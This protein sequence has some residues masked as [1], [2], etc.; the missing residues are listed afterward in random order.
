MESH[1]AKKDYY[2]ILGVSSSAKADE[3]KKAYRKL[4][5]Q[6]HPDKNQGNK[7]AEEKFKEISEAYDVLS[8]PEKRKNYDT[9][10]TDDLR[11]NPFNQ[12]GFKGG[13][14]DFSGFRRGQ[15]DDVDS[16]E[17]AFG[18]LFGDFFKTARRGNSGGFGIR[19][20]GADLRYTLQIGFDEASQGCEKTISFVRQRNST[21]EEARLQVKVPRGVKPDQKLKLKGEGDG[22]THG[23]PNGDLYVIVKILNHSLFTRE[24]E[25]VLLDLPVNF[26]DAI[27]GTTIEIPTLTG[28]ASLSI[29]PGTHSGQIFRLKG[30]GY[31]K[32]SGFGSGDMLVKILIDVPKSV[33]SETAKQLEMLRKNFEE[34]PSVKS[35]HDKVIQLTRGTK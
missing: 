4:A 6:F 15:P 1:L 31:P 27:L 24:D 2:K 13:F 32:M 30:K 26:I 16:F 14:N 23:G 33:S 11:S 35:F 10:G 17:D 21:E 25:N 8:D 7:K 9:F 28:R 5:M 12:G 29:P 19:T 18:D 3:I 22:G 34:P 20:K